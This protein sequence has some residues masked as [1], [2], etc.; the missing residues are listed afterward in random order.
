LQSEADGGKNEA[1]DVNPPPEKRRKER[2]QNETTGRLC[3]R[4][5]ANRVIYDYIM[6]QRLITEGAELDQFC[7]VFDYWHN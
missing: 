6:N 4:G 3:P 1:T 5:A 7:E 2:K